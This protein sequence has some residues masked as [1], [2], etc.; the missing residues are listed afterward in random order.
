MPG[1]RYSVR[2]APDQKAYTYTGE[3]GCELPLCVAIT[4]FAQSR[5]WMKPAETNRWIH[6]AELHPNWSLT[7]SNERECHHL[8]V[9][10]VSR[11]HGKTNTETHFPAQGGG[12]GAV[13]D[14]AWNLRWQ[15]SCVKSRMVE[16]L[17]APRLRDQSSE[18]W[19]S[20][21]ISNTYKWCAFA[22]M[23]SELS[24]LTDIFKLR[25]NK[26]ELAIAAYLTIITTPYGISWRL[27]GLW[28]KARP[29]TWKRWSHR[30]HH[31]H[32]IS[33]STMARALATS[34]R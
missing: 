9:R 26:V 33:L 15:S 16:D 31:R 10:L 3:Q 23:I 11:I 2:T 1:L 34:P 4:I 6:I 22:T 24:F 7:T 20:S 27:L 13:S 8:L 21:R 30:W 12:L 32:E 17:G 29:R 25:A 14:L 19:E 28:N 5:A 18:H